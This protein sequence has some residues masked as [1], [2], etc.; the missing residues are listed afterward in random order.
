[1]PRKKSGVSLILF[2]N[3]FLLFCLIAVPCLPATIVVNT[4]ADDNTVNGNCTLREAI[5]SVNLSLAVDGCT[6]GDAVNDIIDLT[7]MSG[8]I[9]L[10]SVLPDITKNV[11]IIGPGY[12]YFTVNAN[13]TGRVFTINSSGSNKTVTISDLTI[14]GGN[15]V[16]SG[17][18]IFVSAGDTLNLSSSVI[19]YSHAPNGGGIFNAGD[20]V[21]N[22][23][24]IENN[25]AQQYG[26]GIY[27]QTGAMT[28]V[29]SSIQ[30]NTAV[31]FYGGG[32]F[33]RDGVVNFDNSVIGANTAPW[34][35]GLSMAQGTTTILRSVLANNM[36]SNGCGGGIYTQNGT[37]TVS[38]SNIAMNTAGTPGSG[39]SGGGIFAN[40][41]FTLTD[42]I[43]YGNQAGGGAGLTVQGNGVIVNSTISGNT[44]TFGFFFGAGIQNTA[45]NS[46]TITITNSTIANNT[47][48]GLT[49][50]RYATLKNVILA[51]NSSGN[52]SGTITSQGH[53]L[54]SGS[55]CGL[56][57]AGDLSST[58]PLLGPLEGGTHALLPGS[59]AID[60]GDSI[61]CPT[62]DQRG[63]SR[64]QDGNGDGSSVCD[65]GAFER[66]P[67]DLT[68]SEG[69]IGTLI[70]LTGADFGAKKGK[71]L[72]GGETAKIVKDG[73]TRNSV[74]CEIRKPL[75]PGMIYDVTVQRKEPRG[76]IPITSIGVFT[77][78]A[79][80]IISV[81][82]DSG[83]TPDEILIRGN[84]FGSKKGKIYLENPV[85][86][87]QKS[88]K[89]KEWS[90]YDLVNGDG[91]IWFVVPKVSSKFP[92]GEYLLKVSNKVGTTTASNNLT[93]EP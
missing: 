16:N 22:G 72:V 32:M 65:I 15:D 85:S 4:T 43:V 61:G 76:V 7:G 63:I 26:G 9:T 40:M 10:G 48:I 20:V 64:P 54:D 31:G 36:A 82:P 52:C 30:A 42:S 53:N 88:C 75:T 25:S 21:M 33:I 50:E 81:E 89:V 35:G 44:S 14:T 29:N 58:D 11:S 39:W 77:M 34:G 66:L 92:A 73:W 79:P 47:G 83:S 74:T 38:N 86:K 55:T 5:R 80:E 78:L 87:E 45:C 46:C 27:T 51:N 2:F 6:A 62:A 19:S 91:R 68:V 56:S 23:C 24:S 57:N 37:L 93:V 1:M 17:G 70:T 41:N 84:Y 28:I 67:F 3:S 71:I 8:N 69:T 59:P 49:N 18:A 60:A 13:G 90:M 12:T